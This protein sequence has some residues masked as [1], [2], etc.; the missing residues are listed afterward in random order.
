MHQDTEIIA[1]SVSDRVPIKGIFMQQQSKNIQQVFMN[2][3][4]SVAK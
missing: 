2:I 3:D 4:M 1:I